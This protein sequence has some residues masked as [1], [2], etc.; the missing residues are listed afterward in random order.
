MSV[1]REEGF[2]KGL[3][4]RQIDGSFTGR[5]VSTRLDIIYTSIHN[6]RILLYSRL[7]GESDRIASVKLCDRG[8]EIC[9]RRL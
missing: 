1:G 2:W 4:G 9:S 7:K 3:S 5:H 6:Y 8:L